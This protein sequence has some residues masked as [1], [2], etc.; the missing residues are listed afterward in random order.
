MALIYRNNSTPKI[1]HDR[2]QKYKQIN[3]WI[4][5]HKC[6]VYYATTEG[7]DFINKS[8]YIHYIKY[9]KRECDYGT[10]DICKF[11]LVYSIHE[12]QE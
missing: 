5:E 2:T 10:Q 3:Y 11:Y 7:I 8:C 4:N 9:N 1:K 6:Q 12:P